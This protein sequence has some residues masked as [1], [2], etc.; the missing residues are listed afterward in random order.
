MSDEKIKEIIDWFTGHFDR[1]SYSL[2]EI[3][4]QFNLDCCDNTL[5]AAFACHGYYYHV[6]DCKHFISKKNKLKR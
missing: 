4:K 1:R 6:P 5:L 2:P 3:R